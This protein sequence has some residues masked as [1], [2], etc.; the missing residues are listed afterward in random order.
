[1]KSSQI[2]SSV[3][4]VETIRELSLHNADFTKI[5]DTVDAASLM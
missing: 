2:I 4:A 1:M 5:Q 3:M